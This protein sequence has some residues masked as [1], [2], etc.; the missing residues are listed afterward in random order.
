MHLAQQI[1]NHIVIT[2]IVLLIIL[3][4]IIW[5]ISK[6]NAPSKSESGIIVPKEITE[7]AYVNIEEVTDSTTQSNKGIDTKSEVVK[8]STKEIDNLSTHL[9]YTKEVQLS[10]GRTVEIVIP[11]MSIADNEW[12]LLV[13]VFG[14][15]YEIPVG[16]TEYELEKQAFLEGVTY[17]KQF[18]TENNIDSS[19]II[20]VWGDR[21]FMHNRAQ[22]WLEQ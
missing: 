19:K 1:K 8:E 7:L 15:D 11:S 3:I 22:M 12:T 18:F 9:P 14:I 6:L 2:I 5:L 4:G 21:E 10:D 20:I 16:S 17:V 13:Q